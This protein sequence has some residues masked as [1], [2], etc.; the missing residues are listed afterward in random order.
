MLLFLQEWFSLIHLDIWLVI[1][2][3]S[4]FKKTQRG[5]IAD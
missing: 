5:Q 3:L 1:D 4:G 2:L